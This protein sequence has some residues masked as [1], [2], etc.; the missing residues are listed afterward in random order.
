MV[1]A[2]FNQAAPGAAGAAPQATVEFQRPCLSMMEVAQ[3]LEGFNGADGP[4]I[5]V[6]QVTE[7]HGGVW[8]RPAST[9]WF[10]EKGG[11]ERKA[12]FRLNVRPRQSYRKAS[13]VSL[14]LNLAQ[15]TLKVQSVK[16]NLLD[17]GVQWIAAFGPVARADAD[18]AHG[19]ANIAEF[20]TKG[21]G[22]G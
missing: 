22:S 15:R 4:K 13:R 9:V 14:Q 8:R 18:P 12:V 19:S 5:Q 1:D 10:A 2:A 6:Q 11:D 20:L 3:R 16:Q 17:F 21:Q 7:G